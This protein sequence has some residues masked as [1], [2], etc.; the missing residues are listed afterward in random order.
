[1]GI[2]GPP[3]RVVNVGVKT[4]VIRAWNHLRGMFPSVLV[5]SFFR[6]ILAAAFT[7]GICKPLAAASLDNWSTLLPDGTIDTL[8]G[9]A[10]SDRLYVAVGD[11]GVLMTSAN[12]RDWAYSNIDATVNL[13]AIAYGSG[14]WVAVGDIGA[15]FTSTNAI[16]WQAQRSGYFYDLKSIVYGGGRFVA[17]GDSGAILSSRDGV[18]WTLETAGSHPLESVAYGDGKFVAVG[19]KPAV[20]RPLDGRVLEPGQPLVLVS[21]DGTA[22]NRSPVVG[23][24]KALAVCHGAG[25]FV[26]MLDT[27]SFLVLDES[28]WRRA[29][30]E[31]G[32]IFPAGDRASVIYAANRFRAG[33]WLVREPARYSVAVSSADGLSWTSPQDLSPPIRGVVSMAERRGG[34]VIVTRD[35]AY[36]SGPDPKVS[37]L[38]YTENWADFTWLRSPDVTGWISAS[39]AAGDFLISE[40]YHPARVGTSIRA[41]KDGRHWDILEISRDDKF[42]SPVFGN[43]LYV[44]PAGD[45]A[46]VAI[47][48]NLWTWEERETGLDAPFSKIGF[49]GGLFFGVTT[50]GTF[51]RSVDGTAW[52]TNSVPGRFQIGLVVE[53]NGIFLAQCLET[54]RCLVSSDGATWR[55]S[56]LWP[57]E[58]DARPNDLAR[59]VSWNKGFIGYVYS[60]G[61]IESTNG[62]DWTVASMPSD[63][64][65][66]P[67]VVLQVI[68]E[69]DR[70]YALL[71]QG[72]PFWV[73]S[74]DAG[75]Q[76]CPVEVH[77][78]PLSPLAAYV[79]R[80]RLVVSH[81]FGVCVSDPSDLSVPELADLP[82]KFYRDE[83]DWTRVAAPSPAGGRYQFQWLRNGLPIE[84]STNVT[85]TMPAAEFLGNEIR[86]EVSGLAGVSRSAPV[87]LAKVRKPAVTVLPDTKRLR[88][89]G[90]P[91]AGYGVG[92]YPDFSWLTLS[93]EV[94][95]FEIHP[96]NVREMDF[97]FSEYLTSRTNYFW[98]ITGRLL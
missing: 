84:G 64:P 14:L 21:D 59:L 57:G 30:L 97:D 27:A 87:R 28:G 31:N 71:P 81:S 25:R 7:I 96:A 62:V 58:T 74:G 32:F 82:V 18:G 91:G 45:F 50:N 77:G 8:N 42:Q 4:I 88:I 70:V 5:F 52:L 98:R 26:V 46:K 33:I 92:G 13:R 6:L 39:Y 75:W 56:V 24:G 43:A 2:C 93:P 17:V 51:A 63:F 41:S 37:N 20:L 66:F 9:V 36:Y 78:R 61:L 3:E 53:W 16:H 79:W 90:D 12:G 47:S 15:I 72:G 11:R 76:R 38:G 86:V 60:R 68:P 73:R 48:T 44:A 94:N 34:T 83:Q 10:A 55:D 29:P 22:W 85:L 40:A 35:L 19:G 67:G 80:K 54:N 49:A 23:D 1:M 65:Q 69:S 95:H 89:S